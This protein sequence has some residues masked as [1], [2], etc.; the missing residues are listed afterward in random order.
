MHEGTRLTGRTFFRNNSWVH[1]KW[2]S[3]VKKRVCKRFTLK[4]KLLGSHGTNLDV[5]TVSL[6]LSKFYTITRHTCCHDY[7]SFP[8]SSKNSNKLHSI[9]AW[10][11]TDWLSQKCLLNRSVIKKMRR[12]RRLCNSFGCRITF[13]KNLYSLVTRPGRSD[14]NNFIGSR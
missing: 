8:R 7:S 10:S 12:C 5:V 2:Y 6:F 13:H 1:I 14:A 3:G 9:I 11:F 4:L